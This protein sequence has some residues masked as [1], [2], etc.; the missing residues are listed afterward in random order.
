MTEMEEKIQNGTNNNTIVPTRT[1][2][3]APSKI[4]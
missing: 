2:I 4:Y 1:P 3:T